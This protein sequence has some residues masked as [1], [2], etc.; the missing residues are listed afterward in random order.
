MK[1][2]LGINAFHADS[3]AVL[4]KNGEVKAAIEEEKFTRIKHWSG[5]PKESINWC[6]EYAKINFCDISHIGINTNPKST[7]LRKLRYVLSNKPN[8]KFYLDRFKNKDRGN[9]IKELLQREFCNNE[10]INAEIHYI[11]HHFCHEF[12]L[13]PLKI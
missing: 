8:F 5:F 11:D 3:S 7:Y 4:I 10:T 2:I 6:L 9:S 12:S 1:Y 13:L